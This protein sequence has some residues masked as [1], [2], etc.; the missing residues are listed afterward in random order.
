MTRRLAAVALLLILLPYAVYSF[1]VLAAPVSEEDFLTNSSAHAGCSPKGAGLT[2]APNMPSAY[3]TIS[4]AVQAA[5][6]GETITVYP[7]VYDESVSISKPCL[8][9]HGTD[10]KGVVLDGAHSLDIGFLVTAPGVVIKDLT[11]KNYLQNGIFYEQANDWNVIGVNAINNGHYGIYTVAGTYGKMENDFAMGNGDSGFY[12]GEVYDCRCEIVNSTA[13]GNVVGYS[14]TRANGVTIRDSRFVNNSVG[15][16]PNTLFLDLSV[17]LSGNWE[18]PYF[19]GNHTIVGNV[20]ED[21]NN[22]TVAGVGI[23]QSYGVPIGTGISMLGVSQSAISNNTISGNHLW[24]ITEIT[25]LNIPTGNS[26]TSNTFSRNG[27]DFFTDGTGF[28]GCSSGEVA[29][30]N[31]PPPCSLPAWVRI[32]VPNPLNEL[33][34]ILSVG[35]PGIATSLVAVLPILLLI[36]VPVGIATGGNTLLPSRRKRIASAMVDLLVSGD[37]YIMAISALAIGGFGAASLA[38]LSFLVVSVSFLLSP[39]AYLL[40]VTAWF[41]YGFL[42]EGMGRRTV[43]HWV[44]GL[45]TVGREGSRPGLA[46]LLVKNL[47]IYVDTLFFGLIGF[48]AV[49]F[50]RRTVGELVSGTKTVASED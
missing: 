50:K 41:A 35:R 2:V 7:G 10:R 18:L 36:V 15:V 21:N 38:D 9:V 16:A 4:A 47:L 29:T 14:G 6:P 24:G 42:A 1:Y 37:I 34:V 22:H 19:A 49:V 32:T 40:V 31:V 11:V 13:Y 25:F 3:Q 17:V 33:I 48:L 23:S 8:L 46:R 20:I 45:R 30:G 12:I 39:L 28:F 26:Y 44:L 27:Q 5:S 43:G